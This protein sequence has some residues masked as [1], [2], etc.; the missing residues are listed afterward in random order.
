MKKVLASFAMLFLV[1]C[2]AHTSPQQTLVDDR[3]LVYRETYKAYQ[4]AEEDYLN[5]LFNLEQMPEEEELW[6]MKR[7][8][9]LELVQLRELMLN[10]RTELDNAMQD[11]ERH[12]TEIQSEMKQVKPK[13]N[14]NFTGEAGRRTS[15]GQLLPGEVP[16]KKKVNTSDF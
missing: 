15:P 2:A 13:F 10:A 8:K 7:D 11:W 12:L 4:E 5:L 6:I 3:Y 16:N 14:P 1:G 9:M